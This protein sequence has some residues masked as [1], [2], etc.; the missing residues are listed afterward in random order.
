MKA[1]FRFSPLGRQR[2]AELDRVLEDRYHALEELLG[3]QS[4]PLDEAIYIILSFQTDLRRFR[5]TWSVLKSAFS[6]WDDV[7]EVPV[8]DLAEVLRVGGLHRQKAQVI[9]RLL[10]T[11][12][13]QF[14]ELSL[15]A[16]REMADE[17]AERVLTKLPGLSWKGARCI[18]LYSL[19]RQVLPVDVNTFRILKRTG[20]IPISTVYRRLSVHNAIQEATE[21][22]RRRRLHVNLV[23]HG[24]KTCLPQSPSC[25][26]CP[27]AE[28]CLKKGM[29]G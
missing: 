12:K 14:G 25:G 17:D 7:A 18:L 4:D 19:D 21:P 24:Q 27:A 29:R 2:L 5:E 22:S 13:N 1:S 23:L 3:N 10:R 20:V 15:D 6:R 8:N 28:I 11:V 26:N 16:L 9:R